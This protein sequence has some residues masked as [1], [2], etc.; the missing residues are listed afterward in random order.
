MASKF[1]QIVPRFWR[2]DWRVQA[3]PF[4]VL[5]TVVVTFVPYIF[6]I[7]L[8]PATHFGAVFASWVS[9][10]A[11]FVVAGAVVAIISLA[12]P[13]E[14]SF[15]ARARIFLRGR[16]GKYIDY[17]IGRIPNIFEHYAELSEVSHVVRTYDPATNKYLLA[18]KNKSLVKSYLD[19]VRTQYDSDLT[20]KECTVS[21]DGK[22]KN[23]LMYLRVGE[24][25]IGG[26]E[27]FEEDVTRQFSTDIAAGDTCTV[28]Y[29]VEHW[30]EA[31]VKEGDE[32]NDHRPR[33]FTRTV[34]LDIQNLVGEASGRIQISTDGGKYWDTPSLPLGETRRILDLEDVP[35]GKVAFRVR[36]LPPEKKEAH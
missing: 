2:L 36:V 9:G 29:L 32:T 30:T 13:E 22:Q 11:L 31:W 18:T 20:F 19:D 23:C 35:A 10:V 17:I 7:G 16:S 28:E 26:K 27:E 5:V 24:D 6:R 34:R 25:T 4:A 12:R 15:D 21:P 3:V 1:A 8:D 14:E 33:R